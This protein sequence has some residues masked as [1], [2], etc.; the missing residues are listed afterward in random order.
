M[1]LA[2]ARLSAVM[3]VEETNSLNYE[4][5]IGDIFV[6]IDAGHYFLREFNYWFTGMVKEINLIIFIIRIA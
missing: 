4:G 6:I 5:I 3:N 2:G 1:K